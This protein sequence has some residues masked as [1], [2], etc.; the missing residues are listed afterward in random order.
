M[1]HNVY[2][3]WQVDSACPASV[4]GRIMVCIPA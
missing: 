1:V 2:M 3:V 4:A